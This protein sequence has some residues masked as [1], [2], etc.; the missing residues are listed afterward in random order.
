MWTV[1][2][3][4]RVHVSGRTQQSEPP[5]VTTSFADC[6]PHRLLS[7]R[8]RLATALH[9]A[10]EYGH[11]PCVEA[12]LDAR[13]L[14]DRANEEGDTPLMVAATVHAH[15]CVQ[16]LLSRGA[17]TDFVNDAGMT[18]LDVARDC[19]KREG[20]TLE[21]EEIVQ[22]LEIAT[23]S[24]SLPETGRGSGFDT[25]TPHTSTFAGSKHKHWR[26]ARNAAIAVGR[27]QRTVIFVV[28]SQ[29]GRHAIEIL[30]VRETTLT[31]LKQKIEA[32]LDI[33]VEQQELSVKGELISVVQT[34]ATLSQ[35]RIDAMAEVVVRDCRLDRVQDV[36]EAAAQYSGVESSNASA[37]NFHSAETAALRAQVQHLQKQLEVRY[38]L[39]PLHRPSA[40]QI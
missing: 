19:G 15:D 36:D 20:C 25:D 9:A 40:S 17:G 11:A 12:L 18:A 29:R 14:T 1:L 3:L 39:H 2:R 22:A 21:L 24:D 32:V 6:K 31:Q 28:S 26:I 33:P 7:E 4:T 8:I 38:N 35:L 10:T 37:S 27:M 5:T 23:Q 13:A 30:G 16:L 34:S